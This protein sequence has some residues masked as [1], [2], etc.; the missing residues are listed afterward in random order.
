MKRSG[1]ELVASTDYTLRKKIE[2]RIVRLNAS[3]AELRLY[4]GIPIRFHKKHPGN[5][6][7]R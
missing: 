4:V 7:F 2:N 1:E 5:I 3:V 6:S